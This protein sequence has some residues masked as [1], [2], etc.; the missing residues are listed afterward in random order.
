M[1][2]APAGM[3][4]HYAPPIVALA[5]ATA[6]LSA[7]YSN[8]LDRRRASAT[9]GLA[10]PADRRMLYRQISRRDPASAEFP[11]SDWAAPTRSASYRQSR[12]WPHCALTESARDRAARLLRPAD[13]AL[14]APAAWSPRH[15]SRARAA[16]PTPHRRAADVCAPA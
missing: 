13:V 2:V 16:R 6:R 10:D 7:G 4:L 11:R 12:R 15:P 1:R 5:P 3:G 8:R 9:S 14:L